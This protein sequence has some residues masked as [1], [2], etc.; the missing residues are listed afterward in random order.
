MIDIFGYYG[1]GFYLK[2]RHVGS[3]LAFFQ[4]IVMFPNLDFVLTK[5]SQFAKFVGQ[6]RS[7]LSASAFYSFGLL[8]DGQLQC[9][10]LLFLVVSPCTHDVERFYKLTGTTEQGSGE[11][12][13]QFRYPLVIKYDNGKSLLNGGFTRKITDQWSI[14]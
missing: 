13:Q 4:N 2:K 6:I 7:D 8:K 1:W 12:T 14:F 9:I 3:S 10:F 5:V 11:Q